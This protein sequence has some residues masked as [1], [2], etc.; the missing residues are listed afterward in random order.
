MSAGIQTCVQRPPLQAL[1]EFANGYFRKNPPKVEWQ[2]MTREYLRRASEKEKWH[3]IEYK[4]LGHADFD[5][6][7]IFLHPLIPTRVAGCMVDEWHDRNNDN[8]LEHYSIPY[9]PKRQLEL[10]SG[11]Q[12]FEVLLHEIAHFKKAKYRGEI[13]KKYRAIVQAIRK[14]HP[15][16]YGS[17]LYA[18]EDFVRQ[19]PGESEEYWLG[20]IEDVKN[21]LVDNSAENHRRVEDWSR[22]ELKKRRKEIQA[23]IGSV[24]ALPC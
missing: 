4:V 18:V 21:Y 8:I 13:P 20:R 15:N 12:Y 6:N 11:E 24:E 5:Q 22:T 16:N 14:K 17:Q 9:E 7:C 2:E 19:R 23:I 10:D 1:Q 3:T